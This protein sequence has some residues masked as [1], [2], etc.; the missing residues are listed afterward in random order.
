VLLWYAALRRAKIVV[1]ILR[2][3]QRGC[4]SSM[5]SSIRLYRHCFPFFF[6]FCLF[7]CF[8]GLCCV[9]CTNGGLFLVSVG[10]YINIAAQKAISRRIY[11]YILR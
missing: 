3:E 2:R 9:V 11:T 4:E 7:F 8:F 5:L 6:F 1:G 10:C